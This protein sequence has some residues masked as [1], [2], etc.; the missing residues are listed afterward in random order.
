MTPV[1][2]RWLSALVAA[3]VMAL[4]LVWTSNALQEAGPWAQARLAHHGPAPDPYEGLDRLI[5]AAGRDVLPS[6]IRDPF[7]YVTAA[8]AS[9]PMHVATRV[10]TTPA[11]EPV[12][13]LTAVVSDIGD[14]QAVIEY[15]GHSYTLRVGERFGEGGAFKVISIADT[16]VV[17]E[18][19]GQRTTL[20]LGSTKGK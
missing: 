1:L 15:E 17:I 14:A 4:A 20:Y 19:G 12:P 3:G 18:R 10:K 13:V 11:P 9:K 7:G 8:P 16:G 2:R 6:T 5:A